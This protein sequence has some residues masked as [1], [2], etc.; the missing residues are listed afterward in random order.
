[1]ATSTTIMSSAVGQFVRPNALGLA[2]TDVKIWNGNQDTPVAS[3]EKHRNRRPTSAAA[4]SPITNVYSNGCEPM[5]ITFDE[6]E[7]KPIGLDDFD[8][9]TDNPSIRRPSIKFI[10]ELLF[11]SDT[12]DRDENT[13]K[14]VSTPT[15]CGTD[16]NRND[17]DGIDQDWTKK[18]AFVTNSSGNWIEDLEDL[19]TEC[20]E[21]S[22]S[23][24]PTIIGSEQ[25]SSVDVNDDLEGIF[26]LE[27]GKD[28][29][30]N[31]CDDCGCL[32]PLH[33]ECFVVFGDDYY[34]RKVNNIDD[35]RE[36]L[37]SKRNGAMKEIPPTRPKT[38]RINPMIGQR[39]LTDDMQEWRNN[40][41][42][43]W[44]LTP[45]K[46]RRKYE[47]STT[48]PKGAAIGQHAYALRRTTDSSKLVIAANT[49]FLES[50]TK[51]DVRKKSRLL[52]S[53][54]NFNLPGMRNSYGVG[55]VSPPTQSDDD[56]AAQ[57]EVLQKASL[58]DKIDPNC[59]PTTDSPDI[60]TSGSNYT[61]QRFENKK[62]IVTSPE[63]IAKQWTIKVKIGNT[64]IVPGDGKEDVLE[65]P[66]RI[67]ESLKRKIRKTT[68]GSPSTSATVRPTR[69]RKMKK[70]AS[71]IITT[72]GEAKPRTSKRPQNKTVHRKLTKPKRKRRGMLPN[73]ER[74]SNCSIRI[75]KRFIF[76]PTR[77]KGHGKKKR[78]FGTI[79]NKRI[80]ENSDGAGIE[81]WH[82]VY[83]DGDE[84]DMD[85]PELEVALE[86]YKSAKRWDKKHR[87]KQQTLAREN[88]KKS[89][90][91]HTVD[92]GRESGLKEEPPEEPKEQNSILFQHSLATLSESPKPFDENRNKR[93]VSPSKRYKQSDLY[94]EKQEK[95]R[96]SQPCHI[97]FSC[98][99]VVPIDEPST[100][101]DSIH[102][103]DV[104]DLTNDIAKI[105]TA[106]NTI[107]LTINTKIKRGVAV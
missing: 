31:D 88:K 23:S 29:G 55:S 2:T 95:N 18:I 71:D 105:G 82:I 52:Q 49:D 47:K 40:A 79:V 56:H 53:I 94:Q 83:D 24:M 78:Y 92:K 15:N 25:S 38:S 6:N 58:D 107:D 98:D 73:A 68:L 101:D 63:S 75:T 54:A 4:V 64:I 21:S 12:G 97:D 69:P 74:S 67:I 10:K 34:G 104:V 42:S 85:A 44:T 87:D 33:S 103:V 57:E 100:D 86:G 45:K 76:N 9:A 27:D 50:S 93:V 65:V 22:T 17:D 5:P 81:M 32:D 36:I 3:L 77:R 39:S 28:G 43:T 61:L 13:A 51:C 35:G 1:M 70:M 37:N 72:P 89:N 7:D 11:Y 46:K 80:E 26:R 90:D 102:V 48:K 106:G 66:A 41:L 19:H 30:E 99:D 60:E 91:V 59:N 62:E 84:E 8:E 96:E 16:D 14:S 20:D